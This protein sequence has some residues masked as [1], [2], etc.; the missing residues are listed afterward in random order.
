VV[1]SGSTLPI[2]ESW[3]LL[4][5][6][7]VTLSIAALSYRWLELPAQQWLRRH[8]LKRAA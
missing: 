7:G 6:L 4:A 3:F 1:L 2:T 8:T 5:Y